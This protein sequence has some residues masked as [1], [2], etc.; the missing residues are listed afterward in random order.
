M[1]IDARPASTL[2]ASA[3]R[4]GRRARGGALALSRAPASPYDG[5]ITDGTN[6]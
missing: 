1:P 6:N 5:Q 3:G 2:A 4:T